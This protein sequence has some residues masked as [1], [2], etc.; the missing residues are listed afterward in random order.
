MT[1]NRSDPR[2]CQPSG[3]NDTLN[4]FF[5]NTPRSESALNP[6]GNSGQFGTGTILIRGSTRKAKSRGVKTNSHDLLVEFGGVHGCEVPKT[7][8]LRLANH[9]AVTP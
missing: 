5:A 2:S 6:A 9:A 3:R 8:A 1:G 4:Y 7:G